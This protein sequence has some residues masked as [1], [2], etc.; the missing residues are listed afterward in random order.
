MFFSVFILN[1]P[2]KTIVTANI[3]AKQM[4]VCYFNS[5]T[6]S[7]IF[8]R[9]IYLSIETIFYSRLFFALFVD[10]LSIIKNERKKHTKTLLLL[11][12]N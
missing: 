5:F 12:G 4:F 3:T 9:D 6:Y 1:Q 8:F 7:L 11:L 2:V 10:L